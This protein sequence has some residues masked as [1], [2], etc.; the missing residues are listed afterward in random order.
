M[1]A[2]G[3]SIREPAGAE[4]PPLPE[5]LPAQAR[6]WGFWSSLG[7]LVLTYF[8]IS[9][10]VG[11]LILLCGFS[12]E[13]LNG[14]SLTAGGLLSSVLVVVALAGCIRLRRGW[15]VRDYSAI[16]ATR[17]S[18]I[19]LWIAAL[20]SWSALFDFIQMLTGRPV[21]PE[22][23]VQSYNSAS[24][25]PLLFLYVIFGAPIVEEFALRGFLFRGW[26]QSRIGPWAAMVLI[27]ILF[28]VLHVQYDL[29]NIAFTG[30]V[31]MIL[32]L[33]RYKTGSLLPCVFMHAAINLVASLQLLYVVWQAETV[34]NV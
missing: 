8:G 3:D 11:V 19:I 30:S 6:P 9:L 22:V 10:V 18:T 1:D 27:S 5:S 2:S 14:D 29:V 7:W 25:K 20:L 4:P 21:V 12:P 33:A 32:A 34:P 24:I 15:T 26:A 28:A 16:N 23:M 31:G 17:I 13:P